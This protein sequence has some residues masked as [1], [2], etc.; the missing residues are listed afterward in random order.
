MPG[1]AELF[2]AVLLG[3]VEGLTEF[4]PV[5]STAHLLIAEQV[6]GFSPPGEVFPIVIQFGA[7]LSVVAVYWRKFFGV[8]F[9][10]PSDPK[11]RRFALGVLIAFLPAAVAGALLHGFIKDVLFNPAVSVWVIAVSLI[12][13]GLLILVLERVAPKPRYMDGDNLPFGKCLQI[14]LCQCL[15]I[16]PGVSR[17]GA[18]IL[19]G[20]LLGVDRKAA[21]EFTF[22]LAVPTMLGASVLDVYKSWD[23]LDSSAA[24]VIGVGFVV[25]FAVAYVVVK[26]FIGFVGRYGL[27]PF[28]WYRIA[29]GS[30]L[31]LAAFAM[32][33]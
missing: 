17:S 14:G 21:A 33:G 3:F 5:S 31:L 9:G 15:A 29:A 28:G 24:I 25:S 32:R 23:H 26:T 13:G 12:L 27:K 1:P 19:G 2:Q 7:I 6:L 20:E 18:T 11:A 16:L 30:V 22:Y 10:L 8:L 4:L